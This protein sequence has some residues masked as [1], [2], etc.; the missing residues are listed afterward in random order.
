MIEGAILL[1]IPLGLRYLATG[2]MRRLRAQL[3]REDEEYR[4][5]RG[6]YDQVSDSLRQARHQLR[7]YEVRKERLGAD[8]HADRR[9]LDDLR[10]ATGARRAA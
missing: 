7:Y 2:Q 5:L 4:Q 3:V 8:I 6:R 1:A 10:V 9:R